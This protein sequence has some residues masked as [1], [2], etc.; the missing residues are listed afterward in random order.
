MSLVLL[1][2]VAQDG[3]FVPY[4]TSSLREIEQEVA[5]RVGPFALRWVHNPGE[6]E[7]PVASSTVTTIAIPALRSG[8][9][10]GGL[11]DMFVL[12]RGRLRDGTLLPV[13][14]GIP[15]PFV[16]DDRIRLVRAYRPQEGVL[17]VDR[18]YAYATYDDEEI[19]LHHLDPE[20]E[21]RPAVLS[22]LRRCYVVH[23]L[24]VNGT[25]PAAS[26]TIDLTELAPWLLSRDQVYGVSLSGGA[27][28]TGWRVEPYGG[29]LYLTL[30]EFSYGASFVTNRRPATAMVLPVVNGN[31]NGSGENGEIT[32]ADWVVRAGNVNEPW[33][34]EDRFAVPMD[35]AAAAGHIE[36]WRSA[37]PRMA[38]VAQTGM[39]PEQK[40]AAAEFTRVSTVH[41]D[42]PRYEPPLSVSGRLWLD[43][44]LTNS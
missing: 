27:P 15:L 20:L 2:P 11:E 25:V 8:L 24:A 34:D 17:E 9:D 7:P 41:F 42:P 37:R 12:R 31:G 3:G 1:A 36:C 40:E 18:P 38:L 35:Y 30:R 23:R 29:G 6:G 4:D 39:W 33:H 10:L 28:A 19:E 26:D 43:N 44:P 32:A 13:S 21:L 16:D 5:R 22:G 14:D